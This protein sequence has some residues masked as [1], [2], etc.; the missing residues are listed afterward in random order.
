MILTDRHRPW[1]ALPARRIS[2]GP[3]LASALAALGADR[4]SAVLSGT[5]LLVSAFDGIANSHPEVPEARGAL[6]LG[7]RML[8]RAACERGIIG[9][10]EI[11]D[12]DP[13]I[14]TG[15]AG[16]SYAGTF[17][18]PCVNRPAPLGPRA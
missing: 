10:D 14:P 5:R 4:L 13:G 7:W 11:E 8:A 9:P 17:A 2:A 12:A 6:A 3:A 15:I 1:L 18:L 16:L